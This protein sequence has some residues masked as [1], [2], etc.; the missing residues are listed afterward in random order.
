MLQSSPILAGKLCVICAICRL[1]LL[2]PV[3]YR[4]D[5]VIKQK[6][7]TTGGF[8]S[9]RGEIRIPYPEWGPSNKNPPQREDSSVSA[10]RFELSTNGLKGHC[11]AIELRARSQS[12]LHSI[13]P[14]NARQRNIFESSGICT[15]AHDSDAARQ[16]RH[17]L[18]LSEVV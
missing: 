15:M 6:S 18:L 16:H 4:R 10:E 7:S 14:A 12:G 3:K 5:Q 9:E 13:M 1:S 11:S 17:P 8:V 2:F